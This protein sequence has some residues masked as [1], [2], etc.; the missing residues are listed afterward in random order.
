MSENEKIDPRPEVNKIFSNIIEMFV[1]KKS[2]PPPTPLG[3]WKRVD[4]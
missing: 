1:N 2:P 3:H 4:S